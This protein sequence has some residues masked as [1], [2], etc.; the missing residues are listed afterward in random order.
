MMENDAIAVLREMADTLKRLEHTSIVRDKEILT[1]EDAEIFTGLKR[2][3]IYQ[4]TS[5][6]EIPHYKRGKQVLF[7]KKELSAWMLSDKVDTK[8]GL[9]ERAEEYIHSKLNK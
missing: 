1:I 9:E 7:D 8:Q 6:R 3:R 4:L 5:A 2:G